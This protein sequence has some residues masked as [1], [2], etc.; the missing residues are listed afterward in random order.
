VNDEIP[1]I[2][3]V[4][5]HG[6]AVR[7]YIVHDSHEA[8]EDT[9]SILVYAA[10]EENACIIASDELSGE[11]ESLT[12]RHYPEADDRCENRLVGCIENDAEYLRDIGWRYEGEWCC[13]SCGLHAFGLEKYAVC[14]ACSQCRACG[15]DAP[16]PGDQTCADLKEGWS[17][18][19]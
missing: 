16:E 18:G 9:H 19:D 13:S 11:P 14:R 8:S 4:L 5:I 3:N 7:A 15:C 10:S 6:L 17:C 2:G 12:A 1:N